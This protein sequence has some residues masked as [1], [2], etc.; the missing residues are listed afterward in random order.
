MTTL[1][2]SRVAKSR[3]RRAMASP[4]P[5]SKSSGRLIGQDKPQL[6]SEGPGR[7]HA[8]G[9]AKPAPAAQP[10]RLGRGGRG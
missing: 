1:R 7:G 6:V 5:E 10:R 4:F 3:S 9:R 2:P 8:L